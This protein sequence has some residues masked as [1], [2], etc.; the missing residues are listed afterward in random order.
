MRVLHKICKRHHRSTK[1]RKT[2]GYLS[3]AGKIILVKKPHMKL[4]SSSDCSICVIQDLP[5]FSWTFVPLY[6]TCIRS[7]LTQ[8]IAWKTIFKIHLKL[9]SPSDGK[10]VL[11]K[12]FAW[13]SLNVCA[14]CKSSLSYQIHLKLI[15]PSDGSIDNTKASFAQFSAQLVQLAGWMMMVSILIIKQIIMIIVTVGYHS[16]HCDNLAHH[17]QK[18]NSWWKCDNAFHF[19]MHA[20]CSKAD[21]VMETKI[22]KW[23]CWQRVKTK[24]KKV[25]RSTTL[26]SAM[27]NARRC[28]I[29]IL[30]HE[31]RETLALC[32]S[33]TAPQ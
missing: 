5:G 3:I 31:W 21:D 4:V 9:I 14:I 17:L 29:M 1:T 30:L 28:S 32:N 10:Y 2:P 26:D 11:Y 33:T 20:E 16:L 8:D 25:W 22:C 15:S 12:R 24:M 27:H 18:R 23:C 19:E 7:Y 6:N 13:F